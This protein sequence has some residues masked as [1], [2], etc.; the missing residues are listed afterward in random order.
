M[1]MTTA[2]LCIITL[3]LVSIPVPASS[4]ESATLESGAAGSAPGASHEAKET[5][6]ANA[7]SRRKT[8]PMPPTAK[9]RQL[10][11]PPDRTQAVEERLRSGQ[12]EKPI[13][14]GEISERLNQLYSGSK[15]STDEPPV[16]HSSR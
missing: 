12:M 9:R 14:Q 6:P 2:C 11:T 8:E 16:E 5:T 3:I 4:Q 10:P 1:T 7:K 15:T 13:A